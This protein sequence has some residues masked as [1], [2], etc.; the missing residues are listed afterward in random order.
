M[1]SGLVR[2][3]QFQKLDKYLAKEVKRLEGELQNIHAPPF[4][5]WM[6]K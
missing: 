5:R 3:E 2:S 6:E 1:E 4:R